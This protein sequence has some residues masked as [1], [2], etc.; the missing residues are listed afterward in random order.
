MYSLTEVQEA[1]N[2]F[3]QKYIEMKYI[4]E[5]IE[6][7][8]RRKGLNNINKECNDDVTELT[9]YTPFSDRC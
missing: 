2:F 7:H 4:E 3:S 5:F 1:V 8:P 9:D 6:R